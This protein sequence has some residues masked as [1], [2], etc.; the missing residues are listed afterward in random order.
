MQLVHLAL[1][2]A[3]N[4]AGLWQKA[5]DLQSI[6]PTASGWRVVLSIVLGSLVFLLLK[7]EAATVPRTFSSA[8][9]LSCSDGLR[10]LDQGSIQLAVGLLALDRDCN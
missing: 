8:I 5:N 9:L 4:V 6:G 3:W 1:C 10:G 7:S 2:A